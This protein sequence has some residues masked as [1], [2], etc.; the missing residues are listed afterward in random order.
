MSARGR[1]GGER[2]WRTQRSLFSL[3]SLSPCAL[4]TPFLLLAPRERESNQTGGGGGGG[5]F[6]PV[7]V[8]AGETGGERQGFEGQERKVAE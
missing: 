8:A 6:S 3:A 7:A 2:R 5:H 4:Q 1:G